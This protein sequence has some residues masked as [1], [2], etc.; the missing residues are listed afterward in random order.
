MAT[1]GCGYIGSHTVV[2]LINSGYRVIILDD[3]SNSKQSVIDAIELITG[4]RPVFVKGSIL[5]QD[6]L[7]SIFLSEKVDAVIHFAGLKSASESEKNPLKYYEVNVS[8]SIQLLKEMKKANISRLVFSSSATVYGG[9]TSTK[10]DEGMDL[11][12]INVYG[13]TKLTIEK[14]CMQYAVA[15]DGFSVINLRYFNPVGAHESGLIGEDPKG[16]PNNLMPYIAKVASADLDMLSVYGNDY[17]TPD[18]TCLRDYI[19]VKDLALGHLSAIQKLE[20]Q[21]ASMAI[22]LG[23]GTPHS[24]F[25]MIACFEKVS[26][27]KIPYRIVGRRQGDLAEYYADPSLA[28]ELLNWKAHHDIK[29]MCEDI[30][31][32]LLY[33]KSSA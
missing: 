11:I 20:K 22:N 5:N 8:G 31:N 32:R 16:V 30:Y 17:P 21:V 12:P 9:N 6:I 19:H 3:L 27:I 2:E 7:R 33:L 14:M 29:K 25:E 28:L 23:T 18:G 13:H 15:H 26:G 24:V 4:C 10:Y 1:G